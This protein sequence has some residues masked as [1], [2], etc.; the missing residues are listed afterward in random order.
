MVEQIQSGRRQTVW[1]VEVSGASAMYRCP[2]GRSG[3]ARPIPPRPPPSSGDRPVPAEL[4]P[5]PPLRRAGV[6]GLLILCATLG[7]ASCGAAAGSAARGS[8]R[9]RAGRRISTGHRPCAGSQCSQPAGRGRRAERARRAARSARRA[10]GRR[11]RA[12]PA[13][14]ADLV[15]E[16]LADDRVGLLV[17]PGATG[18]FRRRD[19]PS[20]GPERRTA[21]PAGSPTTRGRR[22]VH[23]SVRG[24]PTVSPATV[25]LEYV[26][27]HTPTRRLAPSPPPRRTRQ[28]AEQV[29]SPLA[30]RAGIEY[31]GSTSLAAVPDARAAVQ[32]LVAAA[33]RHRRAAGM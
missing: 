12:Q 24:P 4:M 26:L 22:P 6:G 11:R 32:Q 13:K 16:H 33:R 9:V 31:V 30:A 14:A 19:R 8:V 3:P 20:T 15:A 23:L 2:R 1:P 5:V 7:A 21:C 10:G 28:G 18:T 25:L 17:G 29:L 27:K